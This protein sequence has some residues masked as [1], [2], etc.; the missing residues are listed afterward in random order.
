MNKIIE[1]GGRMKQL[2]LVSATPHIVACASF[3]PIFPSSPRCVSQQCLDIGP[4]CAG[5]EV[6]GVLK[7][8]ARTQ[9]SASVIR[10][11][12]VDNG[13]T[14]QKARGVC[15][16]SLYLPPCIQLSQVIFHRNRT[17]VDRSGHVFSRPCHDS[18]RY[19]RPTSRATPH[20]RSREALMIVGWGVAALLL[21]CD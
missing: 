14:V 3:L 6:G 13:A 11:V 12:Q 10:D 1:K 4:Y 16:S 20:T 9:F 17:R 5:L 21:F 2:N 19:R 18:R 7:G 15:I 8:W